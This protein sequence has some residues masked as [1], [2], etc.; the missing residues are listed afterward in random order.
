MPPPIAAARTVIQGIPMSHIAL[1]I[2]VLLL[3]YVL[4]ALYDPRKFRAA[5][6]EIMGSNIAIRMSAFIC[7]I[8]AFLILNTHWTVSMSS[9]RSI[10]TIIGYLLIVKGAIRLW[11]PEIVRKMGRKFMQKDS[12]IYVFAIL[13]LLIALGFGY[14]GLKVY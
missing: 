10:M 14:L 12:H 1:G 7:F 6:E 4:P 5:V 11:F 8:I 13:G 9:N 3:I 2:A